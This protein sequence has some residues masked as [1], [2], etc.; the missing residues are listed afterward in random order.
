VA[1][2]IPHIDL[3]YVRRMLAEA[4]GF[5]AVIPTSGD[6]KYEPLFAVYKNSALEAINEVLSS[7]RRKI[8]AV[9]ARCRV[10]YIELEAERFMNLN[11]MAEYEEFQKK[12]LA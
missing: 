6:G 3:T 7:G 8:S 5:D 1:C 10:K 2:D 12:C 4:E 9:F 11:T